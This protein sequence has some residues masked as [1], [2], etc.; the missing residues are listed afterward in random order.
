MNGISFDYTDDTLTAVISGELDHKGA[1]EVREV[2]DKELYGKLPKV[3]A[4]ELSSVEFIDSSGLGLI[5]GRYTKAKELG[6]ETVLL[7]PTPRTEKL[8]IMVGINRMI[9]I[10]TREVRK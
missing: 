9:K 3:L 4:L 6:I 7:N 8:L 10:L 1:S 2:I 5:M